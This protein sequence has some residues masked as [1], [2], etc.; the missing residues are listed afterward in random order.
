MWGGPLPSDRDLRRELDRAVPDFS[1]VCDELTSTTPASSLDHGDLHAGNV[2][3]DGDR[4]RLID[5]GDS[6]VTHPFSS[7]FVTYHLVAPK[8]EP[9]ARPVAIRRLR[10]AYLE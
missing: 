6:C 1:R 7:L 2:L 4:R 5:W 9:A 10:D 8:L 3:V